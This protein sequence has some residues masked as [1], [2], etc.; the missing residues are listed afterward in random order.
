MNGETKS[1]EIVVHIDMDAFFASVEQRDIPF[2]KGKPVIVGGARDGRGV[3][4]AASYEAR[5]YGIHSA[6]SYRE[7]VKR[8]P[9]GIFIGGSSSKY[10]NASLKVFDVCTKYS[11]KVEISSVDEGYIIFHDGWETAV[12]EAS[13]LK[14]EI[15]QRYDL[16]CS[17]GIAPNRLLAKLASSMNKPSGFTVLY[18]LQLAHEIGPKPITALWGIGEKT[19]KVLNRWGIRTIGDLVEKDEWW[20]RRIMGERAYSLVKRL[21][22]EPDHKPAPINERSMGHEYTFGRDL[23]P[24]SQFWAVVTRLCD[25][26]SRRLRINRF[27]GRIV[28]VKLRWKNFE[29]HTKQ[30]VVAADLQ[31]HFELLRIARMLLESMMRPRRLI[32]LVGI[33]AADLYDDVELTFRPDLFPLI[34]RQKTLISAIDTVWNKYGEDSLL[35]ASYMHRGFRHR[36]SPFFGPVAQEH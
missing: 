11:S 17:V 4:S 13:A 32:R 10:V 23:S 28:R 8:C 3:V 19:A 9:S 26:V 12:E 30:V 31:N 20:V 24:E 1:P 18:P 21:R 22:G 36:F 34:K 35:R 29:T 5:K 27:Q 2:L 33:T 25:Q 15:E 6:M 7:A 14:K 16:T